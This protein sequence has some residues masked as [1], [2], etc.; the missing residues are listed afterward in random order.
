MFGIGVASQRRN[1]GIMS[2]EIKRFVVDVVVVIKMGMGWDLL[3]GSNVMRLLRQR[4]SAEASV[5]ETTTAEEGNDLFKLG[6]GSVGGGT[7]V[8]RE[9]DWGLSGGR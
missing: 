9:I 4:S 8:G 7:A 3:D 6:D 2:G 5:A 1:E